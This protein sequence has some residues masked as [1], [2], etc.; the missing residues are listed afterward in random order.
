MKD[1]GTYIH[2]KKLSDLKIMSLS[3]W[4]QFVQT[5]CWKDIMNELEK[6]LIDSWEIL[7]QEDNESVRGRIRCLREVMKLPY[8]IIY[9]LETSGGNDGT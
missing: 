1:L 7:E 2:E 3:A 5:S 4:N 8:D 6:W 9:R